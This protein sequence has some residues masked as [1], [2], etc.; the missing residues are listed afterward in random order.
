VDDRD[1]VLPAGHPIGR[2]AEVRV[3]KLHRRS[4][5]TEEINQLFVLK[6]YNHSIVRTVS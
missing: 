2:G 6:S 5:I 3:A 4:S 1:E